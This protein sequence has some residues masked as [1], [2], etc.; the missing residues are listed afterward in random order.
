MAAVQQG[1][2]LRGAS[3]TGSN[4]WRL[5][6]NAS[7][8]DL[9]KKSTSQIALYAFFLTGLMVR[10]PLNFMLGRV[11]T[12]HHCKAAPGRK[13]RQQADLRLSG[14]VLV[15]AKEQNQLCH[16][17]PPLRP[18]VGCNHADTKT[19]SGISDELRNTSRMWFASDIIL[20]LYFN[21]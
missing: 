16:E 12:Q 19:C 21:D 6:E 2:V 7:G 9:G 10:R 13:S 1:S 11:F 3:E 5:C 18:Y 15:H 20:T 14:P 4:R 8:T 17:Q